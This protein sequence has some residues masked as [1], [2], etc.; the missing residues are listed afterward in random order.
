LAI[1]AYFNIENWQG[2][3]GAGEGLHL[4]AANP[5]AA[6]FGARF[7]TMFSGAFAAATCSKASR[8][9]GFRPDRTL[10]V[11]DQDTTRRWREFLDDA[12]TPHREDGYG[13]AQGSIAPGGNCRSGYFKEVGVAP[14]EGGL[15]G[16]AGRPS[17]PRTP[18]MK[19]VAVPNAA[20]AGAMAARVAGARRPDRPM[21]MPPDEDRQLGSRS[22][23]GV[24]CRP[25]RDEIG[26]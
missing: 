1:H 24:R 12:H 22:G 5:A 25:L 17:P 6:A 11:K 18:G 21:T 10:D 19:L 9:A 16:D 4:H 7:L 23:H 8:G 13:R 3:P 15:W 2:A 26:H 14:L 20:I